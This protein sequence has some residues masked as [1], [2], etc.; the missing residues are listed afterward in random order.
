MSESG[1]QT[2]K[3]GRPRKAAEGHDF[4]L[5][6]LAETRQQAKRL[7]E[8]LNATD[9]VARNAIFLPSGIDTTENV[10]ARAHAA[11]LTYADELTKP[12]Y[13]IKANAQDFYVE[14]YATVKIP[15]EL[16]ENESVKITVNDPRNTFDAAT[17]DF[18]MAEWT[19]SLQ[20]LRWWSM[21]FIDIEKEVTSP[22]WD[23]HQR[24]ERRKVVL[25][26]WT[27]SETFRRLDSFAAE[28]GVL[29]QIA[30]SSPHDKT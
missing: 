6:T 17:Y 10:H 1:K 27:I 8:M 5:S 21:R 14:N 25:P 13:I 2:G 19:I 12:T 30:E 15:Q 29:L 28:L 16:K 26:P 11:I 23:D 3:K 4:A 20:N 22:Y 7:V 18:N 24:N 9:N